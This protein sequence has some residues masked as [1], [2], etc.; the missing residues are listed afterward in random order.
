L[1]A[2]EELIVAR[3]FVHHDRDHPSLVV[4]P[5]IRRG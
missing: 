4:L 3:Q 1:P 2:D 5:V